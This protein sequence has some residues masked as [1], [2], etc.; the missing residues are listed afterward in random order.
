MMTTATIETMAAWMKTH[1]I[2]TTTSRQDNTGPGRIAFV[3]KPG[4]IEAVAAT[5]RDLERA[6]RALAR[7]LKIPTWDAVKVSR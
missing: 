4:Q 7:K 2:Q 1:G 6:L 5:G 3:T